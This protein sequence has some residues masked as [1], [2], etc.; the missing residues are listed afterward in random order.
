MLPTFVVIGAAKCATTSVCD[1][2]GAHPDVFMCE[3]KEPHYFAIED[4]DEFRAQRKWYESLF[5]GAGG[6]AAVGEGSVSFTHPDLYQ[7]AGRRLRRLIPDCQLIYMVRHPIDA[8]ESGWKMLRHERVV[9]GSINDVL[10][11]SPNL[12]EWGHYWTYLSFYR[13]LF[14]DEQILVVFFEDFVADPW[15][16]LTRI[17]V[18]IGVDPSYSPPDADKPRNSAACY[19]RIGPVSLHTLA[20]AVDCV[21]ALEKLKGLVPRSLRR[22]LTTQEKFEVEWDPDVRAQIAASFRPGAGKLLSYCGKPL[23]FW[24]LEA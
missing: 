10:H 16:E 2:L 3:P 12:A 1:L 8:M 7:I 4:P 20:R 15:C 18:H 22:T 23:D 13:T 21:P 11:E 5:A 9:R 6:A 19:G 14:S 17:A 24:D